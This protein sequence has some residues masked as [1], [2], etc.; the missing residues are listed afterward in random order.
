MGRFTI[1]WP[2]ALFSRATNDLLDFHQ[3][4]GIELVHI[5]SKRTELEINGLKWIFFRGIVMSVL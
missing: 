4:Q 5:R 3:F 1:D 2:E